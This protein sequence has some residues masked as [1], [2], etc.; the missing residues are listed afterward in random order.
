MA[1]C[2]S[3]HASFYSESFFQSVEVEFWHWESAPSWINAFPLSPSFWSLLRGMEHRFSSPATQGSAAIQPQSTGNNGCCVERWEEGEVDEK[4]RQTETEGLHGYGKRLVQAE[5]ERETERGVREE[6]YRGRG[7][8][9]EPPVQ[10]LASI[11][12]SSA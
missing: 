3:K 10:E 6:K 2:L 9:S 5:R 11:Q 7:N 8:S 12:V 1:K 4:V